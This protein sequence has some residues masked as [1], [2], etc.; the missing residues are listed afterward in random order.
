M[1]LLL[2]KIVLMVKIF[3]LI[4]PKVCKNRFRTSVPDPSKWRHRH[5]V[6][7]LAWNQRTH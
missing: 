3:N 6:Y 7:S 1:C 4:F 2:K 5:P